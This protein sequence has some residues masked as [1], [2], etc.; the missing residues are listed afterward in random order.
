MQME[1]VVMVLLNL[2]NMTQIALPRGLKG[3]ILPA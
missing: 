3:L 2:H 1:I